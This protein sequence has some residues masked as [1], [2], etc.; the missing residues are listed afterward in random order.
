MTGADRGS[1][2]LGLLLLL[3]LLGWLLMLLGLGSQTDL[4]GEITPEDRIDVVGEVLEKH[5][6]V[7][8]RYSL[9]KAIVHG[10]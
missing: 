7:H 10:V 6:P 2:L 5:R 1:P 8:R 4:R 3:L 9:E